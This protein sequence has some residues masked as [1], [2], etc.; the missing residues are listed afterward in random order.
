M[1]RNAAPK[2]GPA[3]ETEAEDL[4]FRAAMSGV[5]PHPAAVHVEPERTRLSTRPRSAEADE[6]AVL[7]EMMSEIGRAHV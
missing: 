1:Q 4:D 2:P 6:Q 3:A 7:L 5:K